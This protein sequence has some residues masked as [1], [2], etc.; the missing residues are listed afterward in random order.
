MPAADHRRRAAVGSAPSPPSPLGAPG[1]PRPLAPAHR[2]RSSVSSSRYGLGSR[3]AVAA[4]LRIRALAGAQPAASALP[5]GTQPCCRA[6]LLGFPAR[7][8]RRHEGWTPLAPSG[9]ADRLPRLAAHTAI[10]RTGGGVGAR[11][12]HGTRRKRRSPV[13]YARL[14]VHVGNWTARGAYTGASLQEVE[15]ERCVGAS[16]VEAHTTPAGSPLMWDS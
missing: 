8:V 13:P 12:S 4:A 3:A 14:T 9:L 10:G 5:D 2:R 11:V 15:M 6:L 16:G 1:T 7:R